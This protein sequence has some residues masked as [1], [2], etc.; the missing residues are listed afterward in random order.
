MDGSNVELSIHNPA[1]DNIYHWYTAAD[2]KE[3]GKAEGTVP[4]IVPAP[5]VTTEYYARTES[6]YGCLSNDSSNIKL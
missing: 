6:R 5:T 1:T 3:I 4:F 2:D